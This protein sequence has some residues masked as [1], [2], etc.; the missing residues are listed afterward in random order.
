MKALENFTTLVPLVTGILGILSSLFIAYRS[1]HQERAIESLKRQLDLKKEVDNQVY[2]FLITFETDKIN[3]SILSLREFLHVSQQAKDEVR[4]ISKKRA[5]FFQQELEAKIAE[6]KNSIQ[7][8]YSKSIYY[9]NLNDKHHYAHQIKNLLAEICDLIIA[10]QETEDSRPKI[11][12]VTRL[13]N[14]LQAE[15]ELML[16]Q[17]LRE[18]IT[19]QIDEKLRV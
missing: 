3:Q 19:K 10:Q 16:D 9:F 11:E 6:T 8:Q 18:F 7:Q 17:R 2:K 5:S 1:K 14:L 12:E 15:V 13:Q 4:E